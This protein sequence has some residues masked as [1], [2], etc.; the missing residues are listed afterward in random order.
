[1]KIP[2]CSL[3]EGENSKQYKKVLGLVTSV[4]LR[5]ELL[6]GQ[7]VSCKPDKMLLSGNGKQ[8]LKWKQFCELSHQ[9]MSLSGNAG[10]FGVRVLREVEGQHKRFV[11][12][13]FDFHAAVIKC[14]L[15]D[16]SNLGIELAELHIL[17]VFHFELTDAAAS[18]V[19]VE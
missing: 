12:G 4:F 8:P 14:G 19:R 11:S 5:I 7:P 16:E 13:V 3:F 1:M 6:L 17:V 15:S 9:A 10:R 18:T 2:S